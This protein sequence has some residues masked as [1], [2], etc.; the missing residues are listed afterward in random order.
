MSR[1]QLPRYP[2]Q[3]KRARI[4]WERSVIMKNVSYE[5]DKNIYEVFRMY[6]KKMSVK[7]DVL[8]C[9][10]KIHVEIIASHSQIDEL[11]TIIDNLYDTF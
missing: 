10:D 1:V 7:Y 8:Q 2:F 11:N 6:L 3:H 5:L 4:N 9:Y